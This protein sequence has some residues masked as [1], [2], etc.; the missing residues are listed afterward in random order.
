MI[1][2]FGREVSRD[3]AYEIIINDFV[4]EICHSRNT[5]RLRDLLIG[6]WESFEKWSDLK[7][8]DFIEDLLIENQPSGKI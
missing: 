4:G 5:D 2:A 1:K 7:L 3:K 8:E 6:G